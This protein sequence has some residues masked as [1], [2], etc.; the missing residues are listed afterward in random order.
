[1]SR[2]FDV[3]SEGLRFDLQLVAEGVTLAHQR[4]DGLSVKVDRMGQELRSEIRL[5]ASGQADLRTRV[6][7]LESKST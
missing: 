2:H 6:E 1:M 5:V 3:T 4:I 7:H